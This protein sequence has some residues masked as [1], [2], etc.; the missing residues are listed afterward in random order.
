MDRGQPPVH[1]SPQVCPH[2]IV[3]ACVSGLGIFRAVLGSQLAFLSTCAH[4]HCSKSEQGWAPRIS[5]LSQ[6]LMK[7]FT[8]CCMP[9][10]FGCTAAGVSGV[11]GPWLAAAPDVSDVLCSSHAWLQA[12]HASSS[13]CRASAQVRQQL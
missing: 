7:A 9:Q 11:H 13:L 6:T 8:M 5:G 12:G 3:C 10:A 2:N 4:M 1:P